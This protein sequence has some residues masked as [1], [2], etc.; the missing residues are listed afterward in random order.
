MFIEY[1]REHRIGSAFVIN[2]FLA[3]GEKSSLRIAECR[4][5]F[6]AGHAGMKFPNLKTVWA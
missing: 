6:V 2:T 4:N 3:V 1:H 5:N